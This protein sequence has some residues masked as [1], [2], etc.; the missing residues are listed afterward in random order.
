LREA[1][2]PG[3]HFMGFEVAGAAALD[4]LGK[5]IFYYERKLNERFMTVTT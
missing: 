3:M 2:A 1:E 5:A 4:E